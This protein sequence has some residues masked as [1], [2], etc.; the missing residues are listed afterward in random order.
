MVPTNRHVIGAAVQ[1]PDTVAGLVDEPG[2]SS[3]K[4]D[5]RVRGEVG[6]LTLKATGMREIV[7]VVPCNQFTRRDLQSHIERAWQTEAPAGGPEGLGLR[8]G[9]PFLFPR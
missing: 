9:L 7:M 2:T 8:I 1:P 5:I 6:H 3:D 4:R